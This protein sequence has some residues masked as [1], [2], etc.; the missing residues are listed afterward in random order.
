MPGVLGY[1]IFDCCRDN[2]CEG[3]NVDAKKPSLIKPLPKPKAADESS[4]SDDDKKKKT[5]S[6][7]HEFLERGK[8]VL[9]SNSKSK[10]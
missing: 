5:E 3:E 2:P 8:G 7:K 6:K 10:N 1:L 4:S 9:I